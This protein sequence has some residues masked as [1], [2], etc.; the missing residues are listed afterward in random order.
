MSD[1]SSSPVHD[2]RSRINGPE[3]W[4]AADVAASA[5]WRMK[6]DPATANELADTARRV[7]AQELPVQDVDQNRFPIGRAREY[8]ERVHEH[9]EHS[10]GFALLSGLPFTELG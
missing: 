6:V 8:T 2:A 10:A 1:N 7:A 5:K 4:R 9:V 3:V